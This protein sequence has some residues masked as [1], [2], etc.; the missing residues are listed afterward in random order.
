MKCKVYVGGLNP[1]AV[2]RV[3]EQVFSA[4]GRIK[5]IWVARNPP[6]FAFV[7]F[8]HSEEAEGAVKDLNKT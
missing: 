4:Y 5:S 3:I 6:G 8:E 2:E 7:A 1:G